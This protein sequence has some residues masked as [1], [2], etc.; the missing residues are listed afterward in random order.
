MVKFR[1]N[2][3]RGFTLLECLMAAAVLA[4]AVAAI[5]QAIVAGQMSTYDALYNERAVG[6]AESL[7]EEILA[8]PYDDPGGAT[9]AGPEAGEVN[10]A[11]FDNIDDFHGYEEDAGEQEDA[12]GD[13]YGETFQGFARSVTAAYGNV[14]VTAFNRN[15][16]GLTITV[17]VTDDAQRSWSIVRFVPEPV[18]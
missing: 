16:A 13:E 5:C 7:M 3:T 17:T 8:L 14:F 6:L 9:V 15:V 1:S 4:L 11:A 18:E 12:A 10:R 2:D